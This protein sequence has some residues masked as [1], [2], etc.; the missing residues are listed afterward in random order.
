MEVCAYRLNQR[1]K[2]TLEF[3]YNVKIKLQNTNLLSINANNKQY[4][5]T[6]KKI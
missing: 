5:E 4:D 6:Q 2:F 1:K 3:Y